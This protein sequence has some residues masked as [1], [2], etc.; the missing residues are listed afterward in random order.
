MVDESTGRL[1][2]RNLNGLLL[3]SLSLLLLLLFLFFRRLGVVMSGCWL[4]G[5][6]G[7]VVLVL[8]WTLGN[9]FFDVGEVCSSVPG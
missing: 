2:L 6:A 4:P 1:M 9:A 7:G 3:P 8:A 5:F